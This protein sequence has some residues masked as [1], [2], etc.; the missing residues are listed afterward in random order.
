M[1]VKIGLLI[2][3]GQILR[4]QSDA[5]RE[6]QSKYEV[7]VALN[8]TN[9]TFKRRPFKHFVY[10][11]I[12][13]FLMKNILTKSERLCRDIPVIDFESEFDGSWQKLPRSLCKQ[14]REEKIDI[15]IK[16]GLGLLK[17]DNIESI[18]ILSYHHGDPS[19]YRGRPAGFYEILNKENA[20][21][22]IVQRIS[23]VLDGGEIY[24][25]THSKVLHHSYR[26]TMMEFYTNSR[27]LLV[28]AVDNFLT[29]NIYQ[30]DSSGKNYRL[31]SNVE[32]FIFLLF[33]LRQA[34][35]RVA[36]ALVFEKKWDFMETEHLD[37][38]K[39]NVLDVSG[40]ATLTK[41]YAF[42][43][44]TFY[45]LSNPNIVFAEGMDKRAGL[46]TII[47][48]DMVTGDTREIL[49]G[50]HYSY[51][52]PIL[53][54]GQEYILPEV[55]SFSPPFLQHIGDPGNRLYIKG[56]EE[57]RC[58]DPTVFLNDGTYYFFF[59]DAG[60]NS[61][62]LRLFWSA[63]LDDVFVEHPN[64]PITTS[65]IGGRMAGR[66]VRDNNSVYRFGQDNSGDYGDGIVIH[67]ISTITREHYKEFKTGSIKFLSHK[68][69]HTIDCRDGKILLDWYQA[70]F[71]LC[72][73]YRRLRAM[74]A[75]KNK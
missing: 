22:I 70:K 6:L 16:F 26:N 68:G 32:G 65:I 72:A 56:L 73:G 47:Q 14:L 9:T 25:F 48:Y 5:L 8:C 69:P 58:I 71:S 13:I 63:T 33:I 46:G 66:I 38:T 28:R 64:S 49:K 12:N 18:P 44:D 4:W 54:Q 50:H 34:I 51:P 52:F 45:S 31:P 19:K 62:T 39:V 67:K 40:K 43:A 23:N 30:L 74:S 15:I 42:V 61:H 11:L 20:A 36:S 17:V 24:A 21:G 29:D 60:I 3:N 75:S 35:L 1:S 7:S 59:G 57:H 41:K 27:F 55:A 53:F 37:F 2:D 10:Y